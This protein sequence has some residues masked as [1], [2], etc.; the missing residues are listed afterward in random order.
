MKIDKIQ[1]YKNNLS[2]SYSH[3]RDGWVIYTK[4][5]T[6]DFEF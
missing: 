6:I 5:Y 2:L 4:I 3:G 1:L